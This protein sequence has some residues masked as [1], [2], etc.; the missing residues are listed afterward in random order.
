M[1]PIWAIGLVGMAACAE[2]A[3]ELPATLDALAFDTAFTLGAASGETWEVFDGVWDVEG[4]ADGRIAVLDLGGPAVH[5]FDAR[6][7]H[8]GSVDETGLDEGQLRAPS[9]IAWSRPG[10]L[11]VWDPASSWVSRF[12]ADRDAVTFVDRWR[13]FA[14]GET[15]FCASGDRTYLSY[16]QDGSVIHEIGPDGVG[17]SFG[18]APPVA[19]GETLGPDL[20]DIAVEELTPSALLCTDRGVVDIALVQSSVRMHGPDGAML[21]RWTLDDFRPVIAYSDDGIGLGRAFDAEG[22]SHLLRSI[23]P[24]GPSMVLVQHELRTREIPEEGETDVIE[25]RLLSLADGSELHRSRSIP[26]VLAAHGRRLYLAR[27]IPFATL[28]AVDVR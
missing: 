10:E 4:D 7:R 1:A 24:W 20:L 8:V 16:W 22:G 23:V 28:T 21:W 12:T 9:G 17:G 15:G 27:D 18:P 3:P 14:F 6:G 11:L 2:P 25:S 19:G 13:A 26:L 5:V